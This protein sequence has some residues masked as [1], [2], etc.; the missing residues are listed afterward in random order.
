MVD[1]HIISFNVAFFCQKLLPKSS[2]CLILNKLLSCT[3]K[4]QRDDRI[5]VIT[6]LFFSN[7][8]SRDISHPEHIIKAFGVIL[9]LI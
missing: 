1:Y 4:S 7:T 6:L 2:T 3:S 5:R 9:P 8:L